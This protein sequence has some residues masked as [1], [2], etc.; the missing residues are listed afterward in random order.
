MALGEVPITS[1]FSRV[2]QKR[3]KNPVS[4]SGQPA[5]AKRKR[6]EE[7]DV[8]V[9]RKEQALLPFSKALR[10][11]NQLFNSTVSHIH[12]FVPN[13]PSSSTRPR[14]PPCIDLTSP[15]PKRNGRAV[16][17][18]KSVAFA[19]SLSDTLNSP[20]SNSPDLN[21][22]QDALSSSIL[23]NPVPSSPSQFFF[24]SE[25]PQ[26]QIKSS[27]ADFVGSSQSQ[28]LPPPTTQP[29]E[30][31]DDGFVVPSSQSQ[32]LLPVEEIR[33]ESVDR[34][35]DDFV[36][37]SSQSQW[38]LPEGTRI[39]IPPNATTILS[40][41]P[42]NH[43]G[44]FRATKIHSSAERERLVPSPQSQRLLPTEKAE[45]LHD[46]P[47]DDEVIPSSQGQLETELICRNGYKPSRR[48]S[49][50]AIT[51]RASQQLPPPDPDIDVADMFEDPLPG[52]PVAPCKD[53]DDSTTESD[54]EG[55]VVPPRPSE[56]VRQS[57]LEHTE[58]SRQY[59][60]DSVTGQ[61]LPDD[62]C[63]AGTFDSSPG[64]L[65]SAVKDFFDMVGSSDS[66]YPSGFPGSLRG[67]WDCD[68]TQVE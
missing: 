13:L 42:L 3:K 5:P 67:Q 32:W 10:K 33:P 57:S 41:H 59:G 25:S 40:F 56:L 17:F 52:T 53:K 43:S 48:A 21:S 18:D 34:D 45:S 38:L 68:T 24:P 7:E 19:S 31:D 62:G 12:A 14:T 49:E 35:D 37:P 65:P 54:D 29:F 60:L 20:K 16:K 47:S 51:F 11:R 26:R 61:S 28:Y 15:D 64:S 63:S 58:R 46:I 36:V 6:V 55:P 39:Q 27:G 2:H 1:Y 66:N 50:K 30:R 4:Y 23:D 8:P 44:Y 9:A 22:Q